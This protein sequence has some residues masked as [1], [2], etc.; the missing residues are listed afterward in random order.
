MPL[1][2]PGRSRRTPPFYTSLAFWLWMLVALVVLVLVVAT[3][4]T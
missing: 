3:V 1:L 4:M 2:Q